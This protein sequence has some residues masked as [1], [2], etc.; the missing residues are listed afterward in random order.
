MNRFS[1]F[2]RD[3]TSYTLRGL[4]QKML[5]FTVAYVPRAFYERVIGEEDAGLY[6]QPIEEV[7]MAVD[8]NPLI[9]QDVQRRNLA[10]ERLYQVLPILTNV[11]GIDLKTLLHY[12]LEIFSIPEAARIV[13]GVPTPE[14]IQQMQAMQAMAAAA[15]QEEGGGA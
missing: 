15:R 10:A 2:M 12:V 13:R 3:L 4:L 14:Q 5:A 6:T 11:P 9:G 7:L 8:L 1:A